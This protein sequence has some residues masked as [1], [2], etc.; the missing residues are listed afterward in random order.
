LSRGR[1]GDKNSILRRDGADGVDPGAQ[2]R[3]RACLA[4]TPQRP[5]PAPGRPSPI[6]HLL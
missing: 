4:T 6:R 1:G 3:E 2:E 5:R